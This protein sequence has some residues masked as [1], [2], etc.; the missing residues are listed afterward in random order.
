VSLLEPPRGHDE[1]VEPLA[2]LQAERADLEHERDG[3]LVR[4]RWDVVR[5]V[6]DL[7]A[8]EALQAG[9]HASGVIPS[10]NAAFC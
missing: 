5:E 8:A 7:V 1:E 2:A 9:A 3:E 6:G 4:D 10:R